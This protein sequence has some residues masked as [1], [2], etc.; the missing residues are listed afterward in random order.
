MDRGEL[1]RLIVAAARAIEAEIATRTAT[2]V[3]PSDGWSRDPRRRDDDDD[4]DDDLDQDDRRRPADRAAGP[5]RRR[6][7]EMFDIFD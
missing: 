4:D 1:D 2:P 7:F 3:A 5:R 6:W